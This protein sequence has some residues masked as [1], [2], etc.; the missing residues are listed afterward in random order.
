MHQQFT[1]TI[2]GEGGRVPVRFIGIDGPRWFLR[3]LL[4]GGPAEP[5][6]A[7]R[8]EDLLRQAAALRPSPG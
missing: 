7:A 2:P 4:A 6:R 5:S 1:G 8:Y 3:A